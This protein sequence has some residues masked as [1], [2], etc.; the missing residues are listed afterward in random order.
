MGVDVVKPWFK[1]YP[2]EVS[3]TMEYD[4]RPL[5]EFLEESASRFPDKE[6]VHFMGTELTFQQISD[7]A[8]NSRR[9][10]NHWVWRKVIE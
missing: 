6:A 9:T 2:E 7:S 8:K 5:H 1:H 3:Q 4:K 10:Y